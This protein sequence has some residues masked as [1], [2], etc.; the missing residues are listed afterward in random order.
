M[1]FT[2]LP[3]RLPRG[4]GSDHDAY[5]TAPT[6][7]PGFFWDQR[8]QTSYGFIHHTQND[9]IEHVR[10]DYQE[11]TSRVVAAAAWRFA[12]TEQMVPRGDMFGPPP[13]RL[14]VLLA[15]DGITV[16]SLTE[17]GKA[18]AAGIEAGDQLRQIGAV[19]IESQDDI[20]RAI[21]EAEGETEVI[22]Q[23]GIE[24]IVFRIV[25]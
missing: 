15:D 18:E 23:R 7:V 1:V 13:K 14:G 21:R 17:G 10:P 11:F 12:N 3:Q 2:A 25:W 22:V 6:P 24:E 19:S 5:L 16:S 8:G 4:I 9:T 20:R